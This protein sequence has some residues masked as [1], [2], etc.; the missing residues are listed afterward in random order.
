M[1]VKGGLFG[2]EPVGRGGEKKSMIGWIMN[3]VLLYSCM[4]MA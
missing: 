4:K 2:W 1:S 3:E